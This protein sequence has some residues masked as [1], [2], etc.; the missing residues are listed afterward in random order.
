MKEFKRHRSAVI[1][2]QVRVVHP[3]IPRALVLTALTPSYYVD[4]LPIDC[5]LTN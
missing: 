2:L 5:R 3:H 4:M 1:A